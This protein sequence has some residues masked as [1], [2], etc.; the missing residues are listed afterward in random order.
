MIVDILVTVQTHI[1][2]K[3]VVNASFQVLHVYD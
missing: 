2:L 1:G 3:T